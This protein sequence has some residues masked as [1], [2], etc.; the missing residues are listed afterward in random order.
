MSDGH[1][2]TDAEGEGRAQVADEAHATMMLWVTRVLT[3]YVTL[4]HHPHGPDPG[5]GSMH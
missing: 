1:E 5:C 4:S 2:V 3:L